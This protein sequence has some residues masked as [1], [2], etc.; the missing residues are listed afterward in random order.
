M[1]KV[2][3]TKYLPGQIRLPNPYVD[4]NTGSSR[5]LPSALRNRSGLNASGSGYMVGS[6]K[7]AL[8]TVEAKS[9]M[10]CQ[11]LVSHHAF[12]IIIAPENVGRL[13]GKKILVRHENQ[14]FGIK[15]PSYTLSSVAAWG[16]AMG[17]RSLF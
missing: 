12:P 15:Y 2:E 6:C 14:P 4:D 16:T 3:S 8:K 7:I 17:R 1:N 5:K 10:I 13:S 9:N 11:M